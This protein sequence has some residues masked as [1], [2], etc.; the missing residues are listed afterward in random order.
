MGRRGQSTTVALMIAHR[1][2]GISLLLT[3][4]IAEGRAH[5]DRAIALYDPGEHR[6]LATR[7]GQ[8]A[9]VTILAFRSMAQWA[10]GHPAAALADADQA[11]KSALQIDQAATSML[12]LALALRINIFCGNYT[13]ANVLS[14]KLV[15]LAEEK[16]ASLWKA[17]GTMDQGFLLALTGEARNAVQVITSAIAAWQSTGSTLWMPLFLTFLARAFAELDHFIDAWRCIEEAMTTVERTKERWCEAEIHRIA[18][19]ITPMSPERDV[20]KAEAY[21][22]H[23]L[24]VARAHSRQ[25]PG[26]CARR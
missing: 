11:L 12:A 26:T 17:A 9:G 13:A 5:F 14:D 16:G 21:F 20:A 19:E 6:T 18:G 8:D 1:L 7:F 24:A 10:L 25:S 2:M 4:E 22:E 15:A 3:G 23:A